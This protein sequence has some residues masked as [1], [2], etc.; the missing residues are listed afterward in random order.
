MLSDVQIC[1]SS[2]NAPKELEV[3][4]LDGYRLP[5]YYPIKVVVEWVMALFL[6]VLTAPLL[7]VAMVLVRLSSRGPIIYSQV[8]LGHK[9]RPYRIYKVRTMTPSKTSSGG[10][11]STPNDPRITRVGRF[12]R[13]SHLDE[14]PQLWNVLRG[15][16]NLIGPRPE[17][18]EFASA[19]QKVIPHYRDRLLVRP[20][21]TG[22]AQVQLPAPTD[23]DSVRRKLAYDLYYVRH[24]NPWLDFRIIMCTGFYAAGIP[25]QR[26]RSMFFMPP[27]RHVFRTY[28]NFRP[29]SETLPQL[30]AN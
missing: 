15:E 7:L 2:K 19:L 3:D 26:L 29:S 4:L 6:L 23:I 30:Q 1:E 22:L 8:R 20:G 21:V 28:R 11:W 13:A 25:F 27:F 17:F 14:L 18:A 16:M 5:W 24:V 10:M 9:G 12:L